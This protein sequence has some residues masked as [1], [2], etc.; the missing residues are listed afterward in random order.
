MTRP[1]V[2]WVPGA[3]TREVAS[4]RLRCY[5]PCSAL[6][7]AGWDSRVARRR[8]PIRSSVVV[9]QKAYDEC[10]LALAARLRR[11]GTKILLDVCDNHLYNPTRNPL[12]AERADRL[13]RMVD[14][15]DGVTTSTPTLAALIQHPVIRVIDD[16]LEV[17]EPALSLRGHHEPRLVWFGNAGSED[18]RFGMSDLGAIVPALESLAQ[19]KNFHLLVVSNSVD[20]FRRHVASSRL[21]ARYYPWN[22]D[23]A[24][25]LASADIALLPVRPNPFTVCKTSNR[26]VTSLRNGLAVVAGRIPSYEEFAPFI[27]FDEWEANVGHY[28]DNPEAR[29]CQVLAGQRYIDRRFPPGLLVSQWSEAITATLANA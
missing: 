19:S 6:A 23:S 8:Q 1:S 18:L 5:G 11:R 17:A 12:L 13:S 25:I 15:A 10:H 26:V 16:A 27:S 14:L 24:A 3:R 28:L 21:D 9:F 4:A 29:R 22:S 20:A 2:R 7:N